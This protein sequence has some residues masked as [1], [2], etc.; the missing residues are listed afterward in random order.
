M[1]KFDY[2]LGGILLAFNAIVYYMT[3]KLPD[4]ARIYPNFVNT[5]LLILLLVHMIQTNRRKTDDEAKESTPFKNILWNQ[6]FLVLISSGAYIL[7]IDII[8]YL[9]STI[10]YILTVLIGLKVNKKVSVSIGVIFSIVVYLL[11]S[12]ALNVPLPKGLLI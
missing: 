2:I 8:G 10:L 1:K 5:I 9:T 3:S 6:F 7:L 4:A 12:R 11:F